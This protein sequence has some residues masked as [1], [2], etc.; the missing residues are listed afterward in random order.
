LRRTA[1]QFKEDTISRIRGEDEDLM[2][3]HAL[4]LTVACLA[5]ASG[6]FAA[7][8]PSIVFP[9]KIFIDLG[10]MVHVGGTL[11]G[12]GVGYP[13][14]TS[15][16]ICYQER[17]ECEMIL[18]NASGLQ[19]EPLEIPDILRVSVWEPDRIIADFTAPCGNP[20]K[21]AKE[22]QAST[23]ETLIID[24]KRETVELSVHPCNEVKLNHW[25]IENPSF[26][27]NIENQKQ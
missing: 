21:F 1:A 24:R 18:V 14:N 15:A 9:M 10:Y 6:A 13:S 27:Q 4:G 25:T 2:Q 11:S 19:I 16:L 5:L 12:E 7:D 20:F 8:D 17:H 22:W 26:W 3:R 23:S